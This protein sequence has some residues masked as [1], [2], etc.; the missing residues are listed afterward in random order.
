VDLEYV[1]I[2]API[3]GTIA[4]VST[5]RG[6]TV[7][8]SFATPTFVTIIQKDALEVVAMVDEADIGNVRPGEEATFTTETWPDFEFAGRCFASHPWPPS[9]RVW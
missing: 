9:S 4:S 5:Q 2:R 3:S 1:E 6:E 7:A 8:A